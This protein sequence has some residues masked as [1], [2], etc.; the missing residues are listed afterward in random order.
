MSLSEQPREIIQT[1]FDFLHKDYEKKFSAV[2]KPHI[3]IKFVA[4]W[5][6]KTFMNKHILNSLK[7]YFNKLKMMFD[8]S[9]KYCE[10]YQRHPFLY[11]LLSSSC[12]LPCVPDRY[13]YKDIEEDLRKA[14]ILFPSQI[15]YC[16]GDMRCRHKV[17]CLRVAVTNIHVKLDI[18]EL[19][20]ENG[21]DINHNILVNNSETS[22]IDDV[23][24]CNKLHYEKIK[25]LF[26]K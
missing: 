11:V 25:H 9:N 16:G 12:N 2:E 19:L 18:L 13:N 3:V 14:I 22:I 21:A 1:I 4:R 26:K 8:L 20:I 7:P 17:S 24:S 10:D 23:Y 15:N 6:I 5:L